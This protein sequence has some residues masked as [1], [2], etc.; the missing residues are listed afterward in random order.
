MPVAPP[1]IEGDGQI[2]GMYLMTQLERGKRSLTATATRK[3]EFTISLSRADGDFREKLQTSSVSDVLDDL[4]SSATK[5][6]NSVSTS[7]KSLF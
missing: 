6:V 5:A 2:Y 1:L 7:I 3:I 4:K